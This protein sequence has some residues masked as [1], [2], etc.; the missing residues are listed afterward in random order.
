[1]TNISLLGEQKFLARTTKQR[2]SGCNSTWR[3]GRTPTT[4]TSSTLDMYW[5]YFDT[6]GFGK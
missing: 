3:T 5:L 4:G 2:D 6:I 1:M